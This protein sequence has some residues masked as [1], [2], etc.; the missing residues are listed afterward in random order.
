MI[1]FR[2]RNIS[3]GQ[4]VD[5]VKHGL[6]DPDIH[7]ETKVLAIQNVIEMETHN[8]ISKDA[9]LNALRWLYYTYDFE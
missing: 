8:S 5:I 9:L 6:E 4:S 3:T 1:P 7:M 2:T